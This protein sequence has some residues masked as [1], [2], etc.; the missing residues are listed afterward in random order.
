[1]RSAA[2]SAVNKS[3]NIGLPEVEAILLFEADGNVKEAIDYEI[4]KISTVCVLTPPS[5]DRLP[6]TR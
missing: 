2:I 3:L 1:M 5:K 4:N 6:A